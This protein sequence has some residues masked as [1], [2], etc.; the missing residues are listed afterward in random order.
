[1]NRRTGHRLRHQL[2][3]SVTGEAVDTTDK[4]R[5]YEVGGNQFLLG[6]GTVIGAGHEKVSLVPKPDIDAR[7]QVVEECHAFPDQLDLLDVV[8]LQP[9]S[10]GGDWRGERCQRGTLLENEGFQSS[11]FREVGGGTADD[12]AAD[13]DEVGALGR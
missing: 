5:G 13:D 10:T 7:L 1:M 2:V 8:E 3:D 6:A 9:E 11:T 12:A 4:G